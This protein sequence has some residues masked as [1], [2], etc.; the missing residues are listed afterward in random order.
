MFKV[1]HLS[2]DIC[3]SVASGCFKSRLSVAH[4]IHMRSGRRCV[5]SPHA[6]PVAWALCGR[7]VRE[8]QAQAEACWRERGAWSVGMCAGNGVP[9]GRPPNVQGTSAANKVRVC[10]YLLLLKIS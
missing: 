10:L 3:I 2:S 1:F 8:T 4:G 5:R 7:A 9:R 6:V